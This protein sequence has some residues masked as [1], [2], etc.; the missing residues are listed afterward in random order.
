MQRTGL[1]GSAETLGHF[2]FGFVRPQAFTS[3]A[4]RMVFHFELYEK[5]TAGLFTEMKKKKTKRSKS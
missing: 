1:R 5:Y 3:E 4:G 2:S